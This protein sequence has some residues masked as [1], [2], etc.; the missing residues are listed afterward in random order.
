MQEYDFWA[1]VDLD[2]NGEPMLHIFVLSDPGHI[3]LLALSS[4]MGVDD[5]RQVV[6]KWDCCESDVDGCISLVSPRALQC[7]L[8][9]SDRKVP[10]LCLL[11]SLR[12]QGFVGVLRL[13]THNPDGGRFFDARKP[14]SKKYYLQCVLG[15]SDLF[16]KGVLSFRSDMSQCWYL[17]FQKRPLEALANMGAADCR[18]QMKLLGDAHHSVLALGNAPNAPAISD[19]PSGPSNPVADDD[20]SLLA[21]L[22]LPAVPQSSSPIRGDDGDATPD[23]NATPTGDATPDAVRGDS[24]DDDV[25][26]SVP[27]VILGQHVNHEVKWNKFGAIQAEGLRVTCLNPDHGGHSCYRSLKMDALRFGP[28]GAEFFLWAWLA[29][30]HSKSDEQHKTWRPKIADV[31]QIADTY[32]SV[33]QI[34]DLW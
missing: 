34:A 28:R 17:L 14:P 6:R 11:D 3:D 25:I 1:G 12:E 27:S 10:T 23:G 22:D 26:C 15:M 24:S 19:A 32:G 8:P 9:L 7:T 20:L 2:D 30:S 5:V 21:L 33:Q 16:A 18:A 31:Q 13:V 4:G 29:E